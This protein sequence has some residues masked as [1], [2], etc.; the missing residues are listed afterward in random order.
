MS[1]FRPKLTPFFWFFKDRVFYTFATGW[2]TYK[3]RNFSWW[4]FDSV[5]HWTGTI[6]LRDANFTWESETSSRTCWIIT[7][8]TG[9]AATMQAWSYAFRLSVWIRGTEEFSL[10]WGPPDLDGATTAVQW[11]K[12]PP[13]RA[14]SKRSSFAIHTYSLPNTPR[15]TKKC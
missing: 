11:R 14:N 10:S 1:L 3:P 5:A 13:S 6:Y 7:S 4:S 15:S 12:D 2:V 9:L 8:S